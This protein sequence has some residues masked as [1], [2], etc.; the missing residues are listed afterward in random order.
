MIAGH[1]IYP[2]RYSQILFDTANRI[3]SNRLIAEF[4]YPKELNEIAEE[5]YENGLFWREVG[6]ANTGM[7][8]I[9]IG[10]KPYR[11]RVMRKMGL[12]EYLCDY[13]GVSTERNVAAVLGEMAA[14]ES[15][16]PIVFFNSFKSLGYDR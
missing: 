15:I 7:D 16:D 2:K 10:E 6:R 11:P 4:E 12:L 9:E 3:Y 14:H 8:E 5:K 13:C 1:Q